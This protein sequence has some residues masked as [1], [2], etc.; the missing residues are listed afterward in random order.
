MSIT[1][2]TGMNECLGFLVKPSVLRLFINS[3]PKQKS[4]EENFMQMDAIIVGGGNALSMIAIWKAQG[5]DTVLSKSIQ[6]EVLFLRQEVQVHIC[7]FTNGISRLQTT[8]IEYSSRLK[9]Y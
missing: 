8:K 1:L 2:I 4:F 3:S 9:I 6:K 5:I 7:W